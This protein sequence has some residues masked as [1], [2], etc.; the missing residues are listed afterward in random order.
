L[1]ILYACVPAI[2]L[3]L[4]AAVISYN[5]ANSSSSS[6][7]ALATFLR[8]ILDSNPSVQAA[9]AA[10]EAAQAR[11]RAAERPLFNPELG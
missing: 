3:P 1:P 6:K 2:L 5:A 9:Q 7:F 10:I 8:K 4:H 11:E